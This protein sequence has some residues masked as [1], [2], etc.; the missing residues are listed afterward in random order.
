MDALEQYG[1]RLNLELVG[2]PVTEREDTYSIVTEVA[3]QMNVKITKEQI[4]TSHRLQTKKIKN[5]QQTPPPIMVRFII[6]SKTIKIK[7]NQT[8]SH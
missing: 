4:S 2:I 1:R 6:V 5:Q 8:F 7:L 3:N